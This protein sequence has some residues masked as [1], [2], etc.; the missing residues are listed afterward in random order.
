[1]SQNRD[2]VF[3]ISHK[4]DKNIVYR[5]QKFQPSDLVGKVLLVDYSLAHF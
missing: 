3:L 2:F 4:K 1:M 5:F